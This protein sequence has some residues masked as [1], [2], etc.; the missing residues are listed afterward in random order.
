MILFQN[1]ILI[2]DYAIK[3][4]DSGKPPKIIQM[5]TL[6]YKTKGL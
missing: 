6:P 2:I 1:K 3:E 5:Q 4:F